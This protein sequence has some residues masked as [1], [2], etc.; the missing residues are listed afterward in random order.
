[1]I[2]GVI[3]GTNMY[4]SR[5]EID[6]NNRRKIKELSH[7]GAYHSWV[8]QSYPEEVKSGIRTRKLWRIDSL[9]GK[10]YLLIVSEEKPEVHLLE[11]YGVVGSVETKPYDL[12][13]RSLQNG[14][15]MRFRVV[16]NPVVSLTDHSKKR[17]VVKPHVTIAYQ[18]DYF[19]TRTGKN[20][21]SVQDDDVTIIES[22][23]TLLRKSGQ[24]P[25]RLIKAIY[26]GKLMI[27][28]VSIFR[29]ILVEGMGKKKAYGFGMMTVI[30]LG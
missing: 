10:K 5:V 6:S 3:W 21:F 30:P 12:F 20:G 23:Y 11:R 18:R 4:I 2:F 28:D 16:L 27:S 7:A 22:G 8:E 29:K 26:E 19:L 14:Q 1:M 25:L 24:K 13:L 9:K 15:Y 17:G